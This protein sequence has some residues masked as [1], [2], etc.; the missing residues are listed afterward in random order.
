[1]ARPI[2]AWLGLAHGLRPGRESCFGKLR[3]A[4]VETTTKAQPARQT[5]SMNGLFES[6]VDE[7]PLLS[8]EEDN[9]VDE[10]CASM[11]FCVSLQPLTFSSNAYNE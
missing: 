9:R 3:L 2:W 11:C 1:M 6:T 8:P 7:E 10:P 5:S 4:P